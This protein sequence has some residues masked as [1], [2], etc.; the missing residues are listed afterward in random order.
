MTPAISE[1]LAALVIRPELSIL[2]K[3]TLVLLLGLAAVRL[4]ARARAS[5]RHLILTATFA[6]LLAIPVVESLSPPVAVEVRAARAEPARQAQPTAP[7]FEP[8]ASTAQTHAAPAS[9]PAAATLPL[10]PATLLSGLWLAGALLLL[11]ALALDLWKLGRIRRESI[12]AL[13]LEPLARAL[14]DG[15]R[16]IETLLHERL[17]APLTCG[18][19]RPAII[20][21]ARA[22]HW[23]AQDVLRALIHETSHVRRADWAIQIFAR[24]VCAVYWFHPL[25]WAA[26]RSLRL[27]AERACDDAVVESAEPTAYAAQ[28]VALARGQSGGQAAAVLG[29][30]SR[31]DLSARVGA[32]L[33]AT[34]RRGPVGLR[35][36]ACAIAL[37][38]T[39]VIAIAPIR[40]IAQRGGAEAPTTASV[41]QFG[42][43]IYQAAARGRISEMDDLLAR[44]AN[45][46]A[47]VHG[48]G[49]PLIMAAREGYSEIV[50][51][52]LER[53]AN[54]DLGVMFD[55]SPLIVAAREG[56][57]DIVQT[58]LDRGADPGLAVQFDGNALIVAARE[59]H[60]GIVETL[61]DHGAPI[62]EI[63]PGDEN[64]LIGASFEGRLE[65]VQFLLSRGAD[66]NARAWI[67]PGVDLPN[68]EWRTPLN[69]AQRNG[70]AQVVEYL[71]SAGARE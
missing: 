49:N 16:P 15:G 17:I 40:A 71:R 4:L 30:A 29:M 28:L 48:D 13:D 59:G 50:T 33:N 24:V 64:P 9:R 52:L 36:A 18:L 51:L 60:L 43:E 8:A 46:N 54:P 53:G 7:D 55:G 70:H 65:V 2:L 47:V 10:S 58:L 68:G 37:A 61:L 62:D 63:V 27:D 20:L 45:V 34:Q 42:E 22:S 57:S 3:V 39:V 41:S 31:S 44:G 12:P 14:G 1:A 67:E 21:P 35:A 11:C 66:V 38:A 23:E 25:V 5:L 6:S 26:W 56:H 32:V 19:L 69:M